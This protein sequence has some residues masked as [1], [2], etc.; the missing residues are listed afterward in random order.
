[1]CGRVE[2]RQVCAGVARA[3]DV[4]HFDANDRL[5]LVEVEMLMWSG[6]KILGRDLIYI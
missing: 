4:A 2:G 3:D 5:V 6:C 1:M